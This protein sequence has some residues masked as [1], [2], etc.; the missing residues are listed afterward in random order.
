MRDRER[1]R[2]SERVVRDLERL[3]KVGDDIS[4]IAGRLREEYEVAVDSGAWKGRTGVALPGRGTGFDD[5]NPTATI[6]LSWDHKRL[7]GAAG[8]A[9]RRARA[10]LRLLDEAQQALLDAFLDTDPDLK[11]DRMEKR[12]QLK[13]AEEQAK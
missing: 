8:F 12:A 2:E 3:E 6:A 7:R 1:V 5:V 4:T 9:G 13:E 10:A 11:R